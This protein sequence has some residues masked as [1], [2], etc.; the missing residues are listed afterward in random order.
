VNPAGVGAPAQ[1]ESPIGLLSGL[2]RFDQMTLVIYSALSG[3]ARI[4]QD[5]GR[6]RNPFDMR[7]SRADTAQTRQRIVDTAAEAFRRDGIA[8]AGVADL[9]ATAGLTH[10]GFY[11]HFASKNQLVAEA[12][13]V[14]GDV[15]AAKMQVAGHGS[16]SPA[17]AMA[18]MDTYLSTD[19]RDDRATG[20]AVVSLGS[21]IAR[22]DQATR[23]A[24]TEGCLH[25]LDLINPNPTQAQTDD[26]RA[27]AMV[28]LSTMIGA[29]TLSRIVPDRQ[30]SDEILKRARDH[31]RL[32]DPATKPKARSRKR[33]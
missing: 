14:A 24:A 21:E 16:N 26:D 7:K 29:L 9:M 25:L 19:H 6:R 32:N 2:A 27:Q 4:L 33:S 28:N 5:V 1:A 8:G 20:C 31:L 13:R 15:L 30:L 11:R 22:C 23:A 17:A 12:V 3:M 10:G 18:A